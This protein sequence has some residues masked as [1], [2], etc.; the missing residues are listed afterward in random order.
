MKMLSPLDDRYHA[1]VGALADYFSDE[2]FLRNRIYIEQRYLETLLKRIGMKAELKQLFA[3]IKESDIEAIRQIETK[4][5][6][7]IPATNHDGK[8]IEYFLKSRL[9]GQLKEFVHFGLT[10]ED[11]NNLAQGL[12]LKGALT[13]LMIPKLTELTEIISDMAKAYKDASMLG[14]THGQFASP[15][16]F[17]KELFVF[18]KRL[19]GEL[20]ILQKEKIP[21]KL[22]GAVGT[23]SALKFAY[24]E[25]N[26][27]A[28]ATDFVNGLRLEPVSVTTQTVPAEGY[29]H[30]FNSLHII[31]SILLD[32]CQDMWRYI[33]DGW[34]VQAPKA[35]EVGS[36]VMPHKVNPINF[37]NAEGNLKL[38]NALLECFCRELPV[39]R[40]QR[41]LSDSTIKRNFGVALGHSYLAYD[42]CMKGLERVEPDASLML[43]VVKSHPEVLSEAYQT[44]LRKHVPEPYEMLKEMTR[45]KDVT[46]E[47]LHAFIDKLK[48]PTTVKRKLKSLKP[49]EYLGEIDKLF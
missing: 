45:G 35:G 25:I 10:T 20:A 42:S 43:Q 34:V 5:W 15:T 4:G 24:P 37:E 33:S 31:N 30:V 36:S 16:T 49:E 14:R 47:Q 38:A 12:M 48:V 19:E 39:S 22:S 18:A 6:Q 29:L 3:P 17:G 1:K 2:A 9:S 21:G 11:V 23:Y 7:G 27:V 44:E 46:L 41:D 28:F 32:F 40:L 8:A 26:W 13:A